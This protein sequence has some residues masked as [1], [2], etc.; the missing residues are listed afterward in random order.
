MQDE[1]NIPRFKRLKIGGFRRLYDVDLEMR[2]V[3][4]MIGANGVGKTSVLDAIM[5]LSSSAKSNLNQT[6]NDMGGITGIL[7][8]N[9]TNILSFTLSYFR[10]DQEL[11]DYELI[12]EQRGLSYTI[13][14]EKLFQHSP[15]MNTI[16]DSKH[17]ISS[18]LIHAIDKVN[19]FNPLETSLSQYP[20]RE[21][22]ID[23]FW[24]ALQTSLYYHILPV[25]F[26]SPVRL[27]Q[28]LRPSDLPGEHGEYLV[29]FLYSLKESN[30]DRFESLEDTL[31]AAFPG[32][33]RLYFPPVA[34][35]MFT[36]TWKDK[37]FRTP[38]YMNQL[39]EGILRFLWL[40]SLLHSPSLPSITMIDEPEVSLHPELLAHL[41]ELFR[42]ASQ[43][44]QLMIATQSDRLVRFLK[45][46]EVVVMDIDEQ[47]FATASWAD[48]FD[49]EE[50]LKEYTLDEV[51]SL[52]RM[53]GRA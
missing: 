8:N 51:W 53:G 48:S 7:T 40:A 25:G 36:M 39:S 12:I 38:L 42:E 33:E 18:L 49:L 29:P 22:S 35:G 16:I 34:A 46:E 20:K 11:M 32:F 3:M 26:N 2:P 15:F 50:W 41:V 9:R 23:V 43:R 44:T 47:G 14:K 45:P 31:K 37:N 28:Q 1:Q 13:A 17:G 10:P 27:P 5:L 4:V 21:K 52:G 24:N 19:N 30:P 6:L